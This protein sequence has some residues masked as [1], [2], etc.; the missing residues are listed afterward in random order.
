MSAH[1]FLL[2]VLGL[3]VCGSG[4][5][6]I[7]FVTRGQSPHVRHASHEVGSDTTKTI[8]VVGHGWHTGLVLTVND[9]PEEVWPEVRSFSGL[10][11]VEFGWGDEGFYRAPKITI[12]L[13]LR[14]AF[15]PTP[16]VVHAA[17][18][19]G[20]VRQFYQ[21]SDIVEIRLP[22]EQFNRLCNFI[23]ETLAR[24]ESG[25]VT[26][27]G[28]GIYGESVFYRANGSYYFP[29]TCNVW[30][31]QALQQAGLP[32]RSWGALRA[33]NVLAQARPLGT[34]L[35]TSAEGIKQAALLGE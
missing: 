28:P 17:G 22:D 34:V 1:L 32:V 16:S 20:T 24:D 13:C 8:H 27:L 31:A 3:S 19:R 11:H 10:D 4:C 30:T 18:I 2:L 35:Q 23:A 14:A 26:T 29:K 12:P 25:D 7:G 5:A 15:W 6:N 21:V 9:I 33:E